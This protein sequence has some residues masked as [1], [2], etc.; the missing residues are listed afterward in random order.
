MIVWVVVAHEDPPRVGTLAAPEHARRRRGMGPAPAVRQHNGRG[1]Y[2]EGR[3]PA[4]SSARPG[5][6]GS[7]YHRT[8]RTRR[9]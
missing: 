8:E 6:W 1:P 3:R 2:I 4:G 5:S 7:G 9:T